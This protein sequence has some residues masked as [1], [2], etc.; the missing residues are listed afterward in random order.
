MTDPK[1]PHGY[2]R[3][4]GQAMKGDGTWNGEKF[5]KVRKCWPSTEPTATVLIRKCEVV[6]PEIVL[7]EL[8]DMEWSE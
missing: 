8:K 5:V 3:V 7:G 6:Q 4:T 2:K 1:I